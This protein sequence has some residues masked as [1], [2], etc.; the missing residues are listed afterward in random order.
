MSSD[1]PSARRPRGRP[2][3]QKEPPLCDKKTRFAEDV[4]A[5]IFVL[6]RPGGATLEEVSGFFGVTRE[7]IRQIEARALEKLRAT[8]ERRGI[9]LEELLTAPRLDSA[10]PPTV[11]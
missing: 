1:R 7:R 2:P 9:D 3:K 4:M 6:H 10:P 5:Q 11:H 8:C